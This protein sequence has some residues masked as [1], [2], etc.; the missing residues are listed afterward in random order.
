V[1]HKEREHDIKLLVRGAML[2]AV[3]AVL[4]HVSFPVPFSPVPITGQSFG[5][6]L[7][8]LLLSPK[9]AAGSQLA[10]LAAGAVGLPVY[11]GG[12][13]GIGVLLGPTGGYIWGMAAGAYVSSSIVRMYA[14]RGTRL[15]WKLAATASAIGGVAVVYIL[16]VIQLS[17][18][19]QLPVTRAIAVGALPY[20]PGDLLKAA[21]AGAIGSRLASYRL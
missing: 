11:A 4:A 16:G 13:A 3:T 18:A 14:S 15:S 2:G 6:M 19:T 5:A 17:L 7:A 1:S 20:L 10:Y 21:F 8:G 12:R 9:A